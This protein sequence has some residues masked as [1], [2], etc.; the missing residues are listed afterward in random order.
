M[1]FSKGRGIPGESSSPACSTTVSARNGF[2]ELRGR[3]M[4]HRGHVVRQPRRCERTG[5]IIRQRFAQL[6]PTVFQN[7][8]SSLCRGLI[9][10]M[11]D[12]Q[13]RVGK[14]TFLALS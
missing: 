12:I 7:L 5:Q 14:K 6:Q 4:R 3:G 11:T 2:D 9:A 13:V 10:G 1:I 8:V